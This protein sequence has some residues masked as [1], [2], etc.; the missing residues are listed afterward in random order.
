M[1]CLNDELPALRAEVAALKAQLAGKQSALEAVEAELSNER[2][3]RAAAE[4]RAADLHRRWHVV[5]MLRNG[6]P[7][8]QSSASDAVSPS[9][10]MNDGAGSR[11]R[12]A[13][14]PNGVR[15]ALAAPYPLASP[16]VSRTMTA[17]GDAAEVVVVE[18]TAGAA[19]A[20]LSSPAAPRERSFSK[21]TRERLETMA[22]LRSA[23]KVGLR[24]CLLTLAS[25]PT[26]TVHPHPDCDEPDLTWP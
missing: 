19:E 2:Q 13:S 24:S 4:K 20:A 12:S 15:H 6:S 1:Q 26:P 5:G 23:V 7:T 17:T 3:L 25:P 14:T 11:T 21:S 10:A 16:P 18:A 8:R 22:K 9:D